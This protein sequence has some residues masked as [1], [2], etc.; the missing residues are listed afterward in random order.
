MQLK[1]CLILL[2]T[3][4]SLQSNSQLNERIVRS[5]RPFCVFVQTALKSNSK[6]KGK[7]KR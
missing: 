3:K 1:S 5:S 7:F 2:Q 4:M 6:C